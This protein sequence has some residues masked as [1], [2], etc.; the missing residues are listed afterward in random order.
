M[1]CFLFHVRIVYFPSGV[2]RE[3]R[4]KEKQNESVTLREISKADYGVRLALK[5]QYY[6]YRMEECL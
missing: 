1:E 3:A 5:N 6:N 4:S 2:I